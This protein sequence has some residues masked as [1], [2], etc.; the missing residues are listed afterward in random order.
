MTVQAPGGDSGVWCLYKA[1]KLFVDFLDSDCL[2]KRTRY[3]EPNSC[4]A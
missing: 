3:V 2:A 4:V 1:K